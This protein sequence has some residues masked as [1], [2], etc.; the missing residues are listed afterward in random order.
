VQKYLTSDRGKIKVLNSICLMIPTN[1]N[2]DYM[3]EK[4]ENKIL[5]KC[6]FWMIHFLATF[7]FLVLKWSVFQIQESNK[8]ISLKNE[9]L[10]SEL[11]RF[12]HIKDQFPR[13]PQFHISEFPLF[14][15]IRKINSSVW[16]VEQRQ[17]TNLWK[18]LLP[19][20]VKWEDH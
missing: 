11:D 15:S 3:G 6:Y 1:E 12:L 9:L 20:V 10:C 13:A 16:V 18:K 4:R 19:F 14:S 8:K 17:I 2:I 7:L 5:I